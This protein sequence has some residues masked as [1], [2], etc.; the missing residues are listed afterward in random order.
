MGHCGTGHYETSSVRCSSDCGPL[1]VFGS[2]FGRNNR[3][4]GWVCGRNRRA[5]LNGRQLVVTRGQHFNG[6]SSAS[7]GWRC[8]NGGYFVCRNGRCSSNG[9]LE[10]DHFAHRRQGHRRERGN[11]RRRCHRRAPINGWSSGDRWKRGHRRRSGDRWA[12]SHGRLRNRWANGIRR[13]RDRRRS[14]NRRS[15][16]HGRRSHGWSNGYGRH[17]G[18]PALPHGW[19]RVQDSPARRLNHM[20]RGR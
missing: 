11:G 18:V 14:S 8:G 19:H 12:N 17:F 2:G 16:G 9:R 5:L 7:N 15:S 10:R 13:S 1:R 4:A 20:G 3:G 6:R